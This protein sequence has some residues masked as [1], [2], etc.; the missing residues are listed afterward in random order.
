MIVSFIN[1]VV[2]FSTIMV[3]ND[4]KSSIK[5]AVEFT[6]A[7]K[8]FLLE[9]EIC[10]VATCYNDNPHVTPVNYIFGDSDGFFYFATDYGTR[11]YENLKRNSRIALVVDIYNTSLENKA[12]VI[13]AMT[14]IIEQGRDFQRLYDRFYKKFEWVRSDPWKEGEAPFVKVLPHHKTSWGLD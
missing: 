3:K 14:E 8:R 5:N 11:K 2:S 4:K 12:V 7:E 13:Q 1:S 6:K 10:R 9:N